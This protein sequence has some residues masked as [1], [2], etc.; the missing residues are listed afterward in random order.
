[1]RYATVADRISIKFKTMNNNWREKYNSLDEEKYPLTW[2]TIRL[3][4]VLLENYK[5]QL[6]IKNQF[7]NSNI[8]KFMP[9]LYGFTKNQFYDNQ[10]KNTT[11]II[12]YVWEK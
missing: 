12:P 11:S 2:A 1:M 4:D 5:K 10:Y 3:C 8:N 7:K 6:W 9:E